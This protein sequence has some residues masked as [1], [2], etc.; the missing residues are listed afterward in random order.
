MNFR[1]IV[2][3]SLTPVFREDLHQSIEFQ[4]E[5][6]LC[7]SARYARTGESIVPGPQQLCG[8]TF[9]LDPTQS[10]PISWTLRDI[11]SFLPR[12]PGY[13]GESHALGNPNCFRGTL[14]EGV[15]LPNARPRAPLELE[16]SIKSRQRLIGE[17][18][19]FKEGNP[20][21]GPPR[22]L[23]VVDRRISR[24]TRPLDIVERSVSAPRKLKSRLNRSDPMPQNDPYAARQ[25]YSAYEIPPMNQRITSREGPGEY[26]QG[27]RARTTTWSD[28]D[29]DPRYIGQ[30]PASR[31]IYESRRARRV[32]PREAQAQLEARQREL[33]ARERD[34]E[35]KEEVL[36]WKHRAWR[37][38]QQLIEAKRNLGPESA[39]DSM[40]ARLAGRRK[41]PSTVPRESTASA[42]D[43]IEQESQN[44]KQTLENADP[45]SYLEY[46][47]QDET[48]PT[49]A[50]E[51]LREAS[52]KEEK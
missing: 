48:L 17:G 27:R 42:A 25:N 43:A 34:L 51:L 10:Y 24:F 5:G 32:D 23:D 6:T 52:R 12:N 40:S 26:H 41:K 35:Q 20:V 7:V 45:H 50:L 49:D 30:R 21:L 19:E 38:E 33:E 22:P 47:N 15:L 2:S 13:T 46:L 44:I 1:A 8:V 16:L 4:D 28:P 14:V 31:S 9:H 36:R 37:L 18:R 11:S 39:S 3:C 29:P